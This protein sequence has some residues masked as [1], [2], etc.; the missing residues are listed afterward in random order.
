MTSESSSTETPSGVSAQVLDFLRSE[1][2]KQHSA[3]EITALLSLERSAVDQALSELEAAGHVAPQTMSD[4]GGNSIL[5][6]ISG[7]GVTGS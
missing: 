3:D 5:W 2:P 1:A 6:G 7:G 4:Y